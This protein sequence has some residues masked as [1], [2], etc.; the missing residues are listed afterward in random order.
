[1]TDTDKTDV[2]VVDIDVTDIYDE[3]RYRYTVWNI[4]K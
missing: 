2:D 4:I 3:Y 1:M